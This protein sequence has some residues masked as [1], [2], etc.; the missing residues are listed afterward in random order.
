MRRILWIIGFIFLCLF[1]AIYLTVDAIEPKANQKPEIIYT[2]K[3]YDGKIA[4][5]KS[6]SDTP[7]KVLDSPYIRDLPKYD[8]DLLKIGISA[9]SEEELNLI[10]QDYDE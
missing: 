8:Q 4:V 10:L 7:E 9:Y 1:S 3:D 2:V 5:F 6:G